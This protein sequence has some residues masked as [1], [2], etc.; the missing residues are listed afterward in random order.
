MCV[1]GERLWVKGRF[2][3]VFFVYFVLL[4]FACEGVQ[5]VCSAHVL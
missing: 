4:C 3:F 5:L 2:F 1:V